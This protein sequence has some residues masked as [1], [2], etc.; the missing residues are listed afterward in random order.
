MQVLEQSQDDI[1][2]WPDGTICFRYELEEMG[3]MSD[4]YTTVPAGSKRWELLLST[5]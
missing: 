1:L 2:E 4:D 5:R 3:H